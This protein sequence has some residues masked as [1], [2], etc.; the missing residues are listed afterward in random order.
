MNVMAQAHKATKEFF[1]SVTETG[2]SYAKVLQIKLRVFHREYKAM[3]SQVELFKAETIAKFEQRIVELKAFLETPEA[4]KYMVVC[5]DAHPMPIDFEKADGNFWANVE[6]ATKWNSVQFARSNARKVVNGNRE[7][8]KA[9][10]V[11]DHIVWDIAQMEKLI[12]S[13]KAEK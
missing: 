13:M 12:E 7:V 10:Q 6:T 8:G 5:G 9:V 2:L 3:K 11:A 4:A 1:A